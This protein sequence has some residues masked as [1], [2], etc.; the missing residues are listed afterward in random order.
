MSEIKWIRLAVGMFDND[1]IKV[2]EQMPEADTILVIWIKLL[3][4]AGKINA[5]GFIMLTENISYTEEML[6][7]VLAR[8][9]ATIR[10]ALNLFK[11][12]EMLEVWDDGRIYLPNWEKYQNVDGLEKIREQNRLRKQRQREKERLALLP[13]EGECDLSRDVTGQVTQC[14]ATDIDLD[15]DLDLDKE[16]DRDKDK[17][18]KT[19]YAEYVSMT[20]D[21]YQKLVD[22]YG[23]DRTKKMIA[24]LD[25]YKGST[26][27]K[28]KNDY[29]TILSWVVN[30]VI[31]DEKKA[32]APF[33]PKG[34]GRAG[35]RYSRPE[36]PVLPIV[37]RI[38]H[39]ETLSQDEIEAAQ[40]LARMLDDGRAP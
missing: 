8:P 19:K 18:K 32:A 22:Q 3:T 14:H 36:K 38:E 7:A 31:E 4:M 37:E 35:G 34:N 1:K 16:K 40:R 6:L 21:E 20:E 27:K 28:Y 10:M 26:G 24:V 13:A 12:F 17:K 29:R 2:I 15:K 25:N 11:Q 30:R 23:E 39:G 5:G 33:T 9:I